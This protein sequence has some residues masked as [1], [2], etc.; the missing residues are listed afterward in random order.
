MT[1]NG[2]FRGRVANFYPHE[3]PEKIAKIATPATL[4]SRKKRV[5]SSGFSS[6]FRLLRLLGYDIRQ[7]SLSRQDLQLF[8]ISK[9]GKVIFLCTV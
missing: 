3:N 9:Y 6:H 7:G 2:T 8:G 1:A 4:S 5:L